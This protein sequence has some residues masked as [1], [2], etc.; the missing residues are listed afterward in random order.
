[1]QMKAMEENDEITFMIQELSKSF[2]TLSETLIRE[3]DL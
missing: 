1:M 2:P 3:R